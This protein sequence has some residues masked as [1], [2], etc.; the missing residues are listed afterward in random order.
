ML[1]GKKFQLEERL[2]AG[3]CKSM[4]TRKIFVEKLWRR[5]LQESHV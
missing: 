5:D 3:V 4:R 2:R 1:K